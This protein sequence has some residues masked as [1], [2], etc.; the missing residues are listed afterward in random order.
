MVPLVRRCPDGYAGLL[1]VVTVTRPCICTSP[2]PEK[3]RK[4][5]QQYYISIPILS[6]SDPSPFATASTLADGT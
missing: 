4:N 2:F 3:F 6:E 5:K 1:H